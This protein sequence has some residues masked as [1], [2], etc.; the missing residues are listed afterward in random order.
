MLD[1]YGGY[2]VGGAGI[3]LAVAREAWS[4]FFSREARSEGLL[5]QQLTE[6]IA[7]QE[8]RLQA[9]EAGLD[10]ERLQRRAA[11]LRVQA[12]EMYVVL[13]K[14][15]LRKNGIEVPEWSGPA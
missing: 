6:R 12:L 10:A 11:E 9:L 8:S 13:L 5:V 7:A 1:E 4:R 2:V 14:A 15:E 3:L